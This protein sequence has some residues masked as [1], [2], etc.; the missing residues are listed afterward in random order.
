MPNLLQQKV[1]PQ[2]N[3]KCYWLLTDESFGTI[4]PRLV[5]MVTKRVRSEKLYSTRTLKSAAED[6]E[7]ITSNVYFSH[8][9]WPS[10]A[11]DFDNTKVMWR[12]ASKD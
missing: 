5:N 12:L 8:D 1:L 9:A 6:N 2:R 7:H 10:T 3:V 4:C 11:E